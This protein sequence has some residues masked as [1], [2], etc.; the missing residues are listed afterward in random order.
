MAQARAQAT[1][2]GLDLWPL[3]LL[4]VWPLD[5]LGLVWPLN[6]LGLWPLN[7]GLGLT[8]TLGLR[9]PDRVGPRTPL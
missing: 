6:L 5:L 1:S 9:A 3:N 2:M 8:H 4:D 7:L